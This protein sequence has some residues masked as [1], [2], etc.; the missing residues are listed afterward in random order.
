MDDARIVI[1][2]L[3]QK[4][5]RADVGGHAGEPRFAIWPL[6]SDQQ[7]RIVPNRMALPAKMDETLRPPEIS[8]E[9]G[10]VSGS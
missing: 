6:V 9:G 8:V 3:E 1:I 5:G 2:K 7:L 10:E 4:T